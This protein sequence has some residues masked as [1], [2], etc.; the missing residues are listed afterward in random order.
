MKTYVK[1]LALGSC[2]V[3]M[4]CADYAPDTLL[5]LRLVRP[6]E[7]IIGLP[8]TP[9]SFAG[10]ARR[11]AYRSAMYTSAAMAATTASVAAAN[12]AAAQESAYAAGAA[13]GR[14]AAAAYPP[15][16][17]Y[18]PPAGPVPL[19]TVVSTLPPGCVSQPIAGVSYMV[20]G[21]TFYR[22][23]FQGPNLVYVATQP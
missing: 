8:F 5:K 19:G 2:A 10:V 20:C 16:Y 9:L 23:S 17:A 1:P 7:A 12:A 3:L 4:L 18:P 11:T 22:A 6:A 13:A 15:P 14:A 21:N